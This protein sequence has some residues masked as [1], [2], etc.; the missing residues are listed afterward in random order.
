MRNRASTG[1]K[2][3]V[4]ACA[5]GIKIRGHGATGLLAD[6]MNQMQLQCWCLVLFICDCLDDKA[7]VSGRIKDQCK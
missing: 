2:F 1:D 5:S 6:K 3:I 4:S 7:C